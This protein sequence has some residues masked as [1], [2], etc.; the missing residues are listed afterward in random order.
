MCPISSLLFRAARWIARN[1]QISAIAVPVPQAK[2]KS[3]THDQGRDPIVR[4]FSESASF[5][6]FI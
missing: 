6:I 3:A 5:T 4:P 1:K 2:E